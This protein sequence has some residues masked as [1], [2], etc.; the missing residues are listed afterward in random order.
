MEGTE[1]GI[2]LNEVI[3]QRV[4]LGVLAVLARRGPRTFSQLRD[5]LGQSDGGLS[6]HLGVLEQH[7]YIATEKVFEDRR[8]RTWVSMTP[9]GAEAFR[10]EQVLLA[11]LL[12][13]A[14]TE[15][16]S[17]EIEG[18]GNDG[19]EDSGSLATAI[20]FAALL[21]DDGTE[22]ASDKSMGD[23]TAAAET[24]RSTSV[25]KMSTLAGRHA[26]QVATGPITARYEFPADYPEFGSEQREQRLMMISHGLRGGWITV[27]YVAEDDAD[28][29][30]SAQVMVVEL[31]AAS[32]CEAILAVM[33]ELTTTL[34]SS[35][36]I[37]AYVLPSA[38]EGGPATGVAWFSVG[39][40]LAAAVVVA[41]DAVVIDALDQLVTE[42]CRPLTAVGT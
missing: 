26:E 35:H 39:R 34:P 6:R 28:P 8:P 16:G 14:S 24:D 27:W 15:T 41:D 9:A 37:R 17:A 21:A 13:S 4:R 29:Q 36:G 22:G 1:A 19:Q 10:E 38:E 42:A 18:V 11:Q 33:S 25:P 3:H 30:I 20:V 12:V 32:D 23:A 5:V 2:A 7:G 31:A 40:H